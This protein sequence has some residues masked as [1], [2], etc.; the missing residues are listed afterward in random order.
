MR[1]TIVAKLAL[2]ALLLGAAGTLASCNTIG[3]FGE[4]VSAAGSGV[5]KGAETTQ[6][7]M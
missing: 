7:K 6:K 3:G 4:D 2:A 1:I 5:T